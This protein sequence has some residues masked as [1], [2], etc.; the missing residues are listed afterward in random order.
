MGWKNWSSDSEETSQTITDTV[1]DMHDTSDDGP[2]PG[3]DN[4]NK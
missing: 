2:L 3:T 4:D 1:R